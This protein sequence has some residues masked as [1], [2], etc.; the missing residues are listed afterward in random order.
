MTEESREERVMVVS[1]GVTKNK[2]EQNLYRTGYG[3]RIDLEFPGEYI[4]NRK[5]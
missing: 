3:I 5:G 1:P 4:F 2:E